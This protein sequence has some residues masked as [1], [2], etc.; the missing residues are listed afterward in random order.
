MIEP[1]RLER[2]LDRLGARIVPA[3]DA[4]ERCEPRMNTSG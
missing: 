4:F 2:Q 3:D 1:D